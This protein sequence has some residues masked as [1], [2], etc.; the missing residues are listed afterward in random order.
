MRPLRHSLRKVV[1]HPRA[2]TTRKIVRRTLAISSVIL[3]VAFILTLTMDLGPALRERAERAG[4]NYLKHSMHIGEL[5]IRIWDGAYVVRNMTIDGL[6]PKSRPW[7]I[8][9]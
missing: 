8:A 2:Q 1:A 9:K 7:L 5:H 3:A 6:T 4:T